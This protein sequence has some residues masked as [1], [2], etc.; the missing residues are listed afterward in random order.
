MSR[1][2]LVLKVEEIADQNGNIIIDTTMFL[3][4]DH[5]TFRFHI[6]GN[7]IDSN[8]PSESYSLTC[9]TVDD[10]IDFTEIAM[11][12]NNNYNYSLYNLPIVNSYTAN[13]Y[14]ANSSREISGYNNQIYKRANFL[15][16]IKLLCVIRNNNDSDNQHVIGDV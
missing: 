13:S 3:Y 10:L 12:R 8:I 16:Y 2:R 14:A 7:R 5:D 15:R 11:Y 4:Y 6:Y 9:N 1:R